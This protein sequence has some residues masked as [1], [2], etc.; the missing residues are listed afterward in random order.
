MINNIRTKLL[1][2]SYL[3]VIVGLL[4]YSFTQIDL[5]LTLTRI[6]FWQSIQ[7][8]FQSIGYFNRPLSTFFY[9]SIILLLFIFYF[10]FIKKAKNGKLAKNQ[11]WF[12][13]ILMSIILLFSYN[14][15]SYD[16]FN[17]MFDAKIVTT[18]NKN[19][20]EFKALDFPEDPMLGFMHWTHRTYPY[21]PTWLFLTVP[22]SYLGSKYLLLTFYLFKGL[23]V[24][25][26]LGTAFFIGKII[27]RINPKNEILGL[28][29]FALNPLII[30]ES[31]ISAHN[32]ITMIF[33][34]MTS[35]YLLLI[36]KNIRSLI[37]FSISIGVKYANIFLVPIYFLIF[38]FLRKKKNI[39]WDIIFLLILVAMIIPVIYAS[40]RTN[41]QPWYLLFVLPFTAFLSKRYYILVPGII[42]SFFALAQYVPFLYLG[43][44]DPPVPNILFWLT[45]IPILVSIIFVIFWFSKQ[46]LFKKK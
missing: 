41:F 11:I 17:Y 40:L 4:L 8:F 42:F 26:F 1:F 9:I 35:I 46:L 20:Y 43:N 10:I 19:P 38:Y 34:T 18:Y 16:L 6:S 3:L 13:I 39:N 23:S 28:V 32:D 44:W 22:L 36:N 33:L 37:L 14:A 27:G 15:F 30:I 31:L 25:S 45:I 12:L 7:T 2:S 24:I 21:G 29:I 5:G